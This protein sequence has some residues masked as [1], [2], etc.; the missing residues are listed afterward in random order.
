MAD[1]NEK[2]VNGRLPSDPFADVDPYPT[3]GPPS[4]VKELGAAPSIARITRL[5]D[6]QAQPIRWLWP[7]WIPLGKLAIVDGDPGLGK[8]LAT[9]DVAARV[10]RGRAMPCGARG[11]LFGEPAGVVLLTAEDDPADTLRPR[12]DAGGADVTR[13]VMLSG[14]QTGTGERM[15]RLDDVE[16]IREAIAAVEARLVVID[17]LMAYLGGDAHRDNEVRQS[18]GPVAKLAAD[19]GAAVVVVRHLNK[20]GGAHAVYRGG[21]SIGIIGAARVGMLV[22][23]DPHNEDLRVLAATK[24]NLAELPDSLGYR[25]AT[26]GDVPRVEWAGTSPQTA[27]TLLA[28]ADGAHEPTAAEEATDWLRSELA[29]GPRPTADLRSAAT[30]A[31]L[32]WRTVERAKQALGV[33]AR[34]VS[35]G[36][37]RGAGSWAWALPGDARTISDQDRQ[38]DQHRQDGLEDP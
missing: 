36:G 30:R 23:R 27:S 38:D 18:L 3:S 20:S 10:S 29:D 9:L 2:H 37:R 15:P 32:A 22:A 25:I 24:S 16:A 6:V 13:I 14:V 11:W 12:L 1:E 26:V 28:A 21:G 19:S 35:E 17:P 8:S 31:G 7:G 34:R 5:A 4:G 33:K